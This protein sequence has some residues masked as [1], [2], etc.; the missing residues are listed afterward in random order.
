MWFTR[1][2]KSIAAL[3][4]FVAA[5]LVSAGC[6]KPEPTPGSAA[7]PA[8]QTGPSAAQLYA[9]DALVELN[10]KN[11]L[12]DRLWKR[13]AKAGLANG[14]DLGTVVFQNPNGMGAVATA[15]VIG[16][17]DTKNS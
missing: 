15:Q 8:A 5:S 6:G 7:A 16:L 1:Q 9:R 17:F 3:V 2:G 10:S 11:D 12:N 13:D 4:L 14:T